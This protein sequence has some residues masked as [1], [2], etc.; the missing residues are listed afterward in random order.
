MIWWVYDMC[1]HRNFWHMDTNWLEISIPVQPCCY[2]NDVINMWHMWL[3]E[4]LT[5]AYQQIWNLNPSSTILLWDWSDECVTYVTVGTFNICIPID[6]KFQSQ[7]NYAIGGM[8]W[9]VCDMCDHENFWHMGINRLE[10]SIP[11]QLCYCGNDLI[12]VWHVTMGTFDIWVSIDSKF[13]S[14]VNYAIVRMIWWV[15][16]MCDCGNFWHMGTNRLEISIPV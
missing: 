16:D 3:W 6:L 12:C 7:F 8:I 4:L 13:Q 15:C 5:Y 14:Q 1:D 2:G 11:V 10:I 9:W